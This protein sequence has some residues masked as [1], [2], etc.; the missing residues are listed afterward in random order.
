M[1]DKKTASEEEKTTVPESANKETQQSGS[2]EHTPEK[3]S[4]V[5]EDALVD[6]AEKKE[7]PK[8]KVTAEEE[9]VETEA[10]A[11]GVP[12]TDTDKKSKTE[13]EA[14]ESA[15][16]E[17]EAKGQ[18]DLD[19]TTE[20][21]EEVASSDEE[22]DEDDQEEGKDYS[23]LSKKELIQEFKSLLKNKPVQEI[24]NDV[25]EIR[26]EFN[27]KFNDLLEQ[28]KEEFLAGGGNIID[29]QYTT[30]QKKEFNS[31][32]FDYKEK[33]NSYYKNLK[34]DL[35]ANL[36][37]REEI[38]EELKGLLNAEESMGKTYNHFKDIQS[39]WHEA[40]PIPRDKY[41]L[42]W[43]NYHHHVE[44]FY[45]FLHLN[46]EFRDMDFKH[47]LE[48]KLKLIG[49]AEEL[50]QEDNINK[51]FR[52]LQMLHKMWKEDVGPV[53]KEYRDDVWDK[54]SEATKAIHDKRNA[55]LEEQEKEYEA[56][57]E[58]KKDLINQIKHIT[59][60]TK[61][62]HQAWQQAIKKVQELR[63][64]YFAAGKVPKALNKGIWNAFK[65]ATRT[66]NRTKN[67]YYKN[68]KK[69]QYANLEKKRELVKIAEDNKNSEDL[70]STTPLM[71][72]IQADWKKIGHVPR[73]HSDK[74]WKQFKDACNHYFDRLHAQKDEEK[75][76]EKEHLQSKEALLE[77]MNNL[78]LSG[79]HKK[80]LKT[81]KENISE[82]KKIGRV[83]Y[84]KRNI[85]QKFNKTLDGLFKK[86]D[87]SK[88]DAELIKFE[89]K[90]NTLTNR[91]DE[92]KLKNEHFFISKKINETK[93]EIR[94]LENNLSFFKHV[95][96]DN[97]LVKEVHKNIAKHKEQLEV[98]KAK[99]SKIKSVRDV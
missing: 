45:D 77:K 83:P 99:L 40:G 50:L 28:K 76:E 67:A 6:E 82:W 32:Y 47:N 41:N 88:K 64:A 12:D 81:I 4:E 51:A 95:E 97:P 59:E 84:K 35:N 80:D 3:D 70:E 52:E 11:E 37:K 57:Y 92:R 86:L 66:F 16:E 33:R 78:E 15:K 60:N 71:K 9:E 8:E 25:E 10:E 38:I 58:V 24:K 39:R 68:Q 93:D 34:R 19:T 20:E 89:N 26:S 44:N 96:D 53:A 23:E 14:K 42:V 62:S 48:Q 30:P 72:K 17:E 27:S 46:R 56:N 69:E 13:T 73:K 55:Y 21:E 5:L 54:F 98:W 31:L 87:L 29:F 85:E 63:D 90:L 2:N 74:I 61:P 7:A 94:Q 65:D 91:D 43:N 1:S 49:R 22:E 79:D 36:K 18:E 75:E